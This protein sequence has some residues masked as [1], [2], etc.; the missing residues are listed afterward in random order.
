MAHDWKTLSDMVQGKNIVIER[1]RIVENG[2]ACEGEF[3]LPPLAKL[4][5]DDQI[6]ISAFIQCNGSIKGME[7]YFGISYPTVKNR[8]SAISAQLKLVEVGK[9]ESRQD[10]I[11]R[12][13]EG[14]IS[15]DEAI[16][17]L[18]SEDLQ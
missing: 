13:N 9:S 11:E 18:K 15:V 12:L 10:I 2:V 14:K 17:R 5:Y 6:F 7:Q 3:E 16:E 4:S 8:L 1:I